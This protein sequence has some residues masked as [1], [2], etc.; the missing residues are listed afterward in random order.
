MWSEK[1]VRSTLELNDRELREMCN[2]G[3]LLGLTAADAL[4][5]RYPVFQFERHDATVRVKPALAAFMTLLSYRD[6]WTTAI[7]AKTPAPELDGLSPLEWVNLGH[8]ERSL[9]DYA[10]ILRAEFER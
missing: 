10:H 8:D 1:K 3:Q 6:P 5:I 9:R 4:T 7:V 2:A